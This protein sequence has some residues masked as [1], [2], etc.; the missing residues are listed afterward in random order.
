MLTN[1]QLQV[2]V[3]DLLWEDGLPA[4]VSLDYPALRI[5]HSA[6]EAPHQVAHQ[7][8]LPVRV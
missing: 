8:A 5:P 7:P 4:L 3:S 1:G 6:L 2:T